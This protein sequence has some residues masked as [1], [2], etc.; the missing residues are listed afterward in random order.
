MLFKVKQIIFVCFL[1]FIAQVSIIECTR[2]KTNLKSE[3]CS[4]KLR[5]MPHNE[6][7]AVSFISEMQDGLEDFNFCKKPNNKFLIKKFLIFR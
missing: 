4:I 3:G 5:K 7:E 1:I 6:V 2:L